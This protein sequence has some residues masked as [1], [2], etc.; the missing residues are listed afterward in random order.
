METY[1]L[2]PSPDLHPELAVLVAALLDSTK[3]WQENLERPA[4]EAMIWQPYP[5]GPRHRRR[6]P[7][8]ASC[9]TY[10]LDEFIN[11]KPA[12]LTDPAVSYD[13]SMD[14]YIPYWPVPPNE[15]YEWYLNQLKV[16]SCKSA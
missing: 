9:E 10:W 3:E 16:H 13:R 2:H 6:H 4:Q 12:D 11:S 8:L 15:P 14:Q 5:N 1:D 7:H